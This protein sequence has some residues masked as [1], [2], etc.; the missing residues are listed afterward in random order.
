MTLA[1]LL[2]LI[3]A[4]HVYELNF[5]TFAKG[6]SHLQYHPPRDDQDVWDW[7]HDQHK[8]ETA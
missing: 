8:E 6:V 7:A 2:E 1:H 4:C 5:K 3:Q